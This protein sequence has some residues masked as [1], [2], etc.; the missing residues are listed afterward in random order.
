MFTHAKNIKTQILDYASA[1]VAH[2][3]C[4]MVVMMVRTLTKG[5]FRRGLLE[6]SNDQ[7]T[8]AA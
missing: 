5:I 7:V 6:G 2:A 8:L 4:S 3:C 1:L